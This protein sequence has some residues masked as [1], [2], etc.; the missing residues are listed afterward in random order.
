MDMTD[1]AAQA[2]VLEDQ[3][4]RMLNAAEKV[5]DNATGPLDPA[6]GALVH[7]VLYGVRH[8]TY[9]QSNLRI[10]SEALD[11]LHLRADGLM[12]RL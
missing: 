10:G 1:G 7:A 6:T 2:S 8:V 11:A 9:T 12:P 3:M 4:T 5:L